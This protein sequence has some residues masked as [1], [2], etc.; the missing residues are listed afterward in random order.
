MIIV[1]TREPDIIYN[2]LAKRKVDIKR[3][4]VEFTDYLIVHKEYVIPVE[5]KTAPDFV[6]SII[7]RRVFNQAY[8]LSTMFPVAYI[9]VEGSI[10][11]AMFEHKFREEAYIGALVSL[12]LKR[13][14]Y[15]RR[16][17]ISVINVE[18][19][20]HTAMFLYYLHKKVLEE[21]FDR[22][23]RINI[24]GK[25]MI[26]KKGVMIAMLQAV[27]GV[28]EEKARRIAERFNSV[29]EII[30]APLPLLTA[31]EGVSTKLAK[32]IKEYLS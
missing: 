27:P 4:D 25:T 22:L 1:D 16:G 6:Q 11:E 7:D 3:Q 17:H 18:T 9:I 8:L 31:I 29:K 12:A 26:D 30:E 24:R 14:P 2:Y 19:E 13:S 21:D 10:S 23:P 28:G 32:R 5:R 20:I 15:G